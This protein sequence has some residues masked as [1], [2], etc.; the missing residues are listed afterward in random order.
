MASSGQTRQ[1]VS[2]I[3]TY[4]IDYEHD[5]PSGA[6]VSSAAVTHIPPSGSASVPSVG[7]S[8]PNVSVQVGPLTTPGRHVFVILATL[9]NGDISEF[10]LIIQ[11]P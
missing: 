9:S 11:V 10:D 1:S 3:V 6:T 7:L 8:S 5:L 4:T 2:E